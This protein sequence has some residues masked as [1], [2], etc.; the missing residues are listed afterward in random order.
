MKTKWFYHKNC[1]GDDNSRAPLFLTEIDKAWHNSDV[2]Y[3]RPIN[4]SK[5]MSVRMHESDHE[6]S[7]QSL[8]AI[9]ICF[10]FEA[11]GRRVEWAVTPL[12]PPPP[13]PTER[14]LR[15]TD[16]KTIHQFS[17]LMPSLPVIRLPYIPCFLDTMAPAWLFIFTP[18]NLIMNS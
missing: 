2:V 6:M 17:F 11:I 1:A 3:G 13:P 10:C 8:V 5:N 18:K 14:V 15:C 7:M 4:A 12:P 16:H 9:G